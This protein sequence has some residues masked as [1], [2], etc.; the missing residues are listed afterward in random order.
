MTEEQKKNIAQAEAQI[1]VIGWV[2]DH[3]PNQNRCKACEDILN[4][5]IAPLLDLREKT[6]SK[7]VAASSGGGSGS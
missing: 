7:P 2:L 4:D 3:E 1:G 6:T 5:W